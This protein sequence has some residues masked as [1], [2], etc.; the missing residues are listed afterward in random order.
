MFST[1]RVNLDGD[2]YHR[3][4]SPTLGQLACEASDG[5]AVKRADLR[6]A[7]ERQHAA[8]QGRLVTP[9]GLGLKP[10]YTDLP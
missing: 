10:E 4:T 2:L 8:P 3:R 6:L 7:E 1:W 5:T 9:A